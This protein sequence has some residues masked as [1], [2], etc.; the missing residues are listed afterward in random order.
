MLIVLLLDIYRKA[1]FPYLARAIVKNDAGED[2]RTRKWNEN[3]FTDTFHPR[4]A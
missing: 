3:V 1:T 2:S 4:I